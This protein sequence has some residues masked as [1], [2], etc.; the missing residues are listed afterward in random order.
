MTRIQRVPV[1]VRAGLLLLGGVLLLGTLRN[2]LQLADVSADALTVVTGGL[3]IVSVVGPNAI[4]MLRARLRRPV[5][6]P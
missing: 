4:R 1:A 2:A 3:L 5:S 6:Q